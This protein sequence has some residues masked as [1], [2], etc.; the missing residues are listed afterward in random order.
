MNRHTFISLLLVVLATGCAM[1][2]TPQNA[3]EQRNYVRKGLFGSAFETYSVNRPYYKVVKT[4]KVNTKKCLNKKIK[5][6][7]CGGSTSGCRTQITTYTPTFIQGRKKSELHVQVVESNV[8]RI[9]GKAPKGGLHIAVID[10]IRLGKK[11]TQISVYTLDRRF[12]AI[13]VAVKRWVKDTN[14]GCPDLA[15]KM[16]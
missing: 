12:R 7:T 9:S 5:V 3:E 8:R 1:G 6:K 2:P 10:I 13:P 11:K 14:L 16:F 4:L 15:P